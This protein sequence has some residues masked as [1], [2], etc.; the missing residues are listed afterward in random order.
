[1]TFFSL[2][3]LL[4]ILITFAVYYMVPRN[5]QWVVLLLSG[6]VFYYFAGGLK[7][8]AFLLVTSVITY[9]TG[10]SMQK[11]A[12]EGKELASQAQDRQ[13]RSAVREKTKK[14]LKAKMWTGAALDLLILGYS[15]YLNFL[16]AQFAGLFRMDPVPV[17][18]V[19]VPLGISFYTFQSVGYLADIELGRVKAQENYLK[20]FLFTSFFPSIVQGP[21]CKYADL[22]P[23]LYAAREYDHGNTVRGIA[24]MM[25][26]Y[27]KKVVIADRAGILVKVCSPTMRRRITAASP[28]CWRCWSTECRYIRISPAA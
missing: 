12:D 26:G 6:C 13:Q 17:F 11:T 14:T 1:M 23:Q 15:K 9:F 27:I 7:A 25:L 21:I 4:L 19:I 3:F 18:S 20:F 24:R 2:G 10:L 28:S 22:S 8:F 16:A 5:L